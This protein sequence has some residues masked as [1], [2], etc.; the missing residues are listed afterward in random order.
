MKKKRK[1]QIKLGTLVLLILYFLVLVYV[2]FIS[3]AYGRAELSDTYHYN[4]IPFKEI[5]R[6]YI[7]RDVVG[8]KAFVLN[9]FGNVIA[10][11]PFGLFIPILFSRKRHLKS[12]L[13]MTFLLSMGIEIIQLLTRTGSFDVDDLILN[14]LGGV[15]GYLLFVVLDYIRRYRYGS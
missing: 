13:R 1:Y 11:M 10:F 4:L 7:Y 12:I 2:C 5:A 3:E 15:L 14:T 9:L 6:F 8:G